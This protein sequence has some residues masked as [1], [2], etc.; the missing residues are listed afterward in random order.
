V[1]LRFADPNWFM[2]VGLAVPMAVLAFVWFRAMSGPRRW[3]AV[4]L[5]TLVLLIIAALLAGA[6]VVRTSEKMALMVVMD[7]S[8]SVREL[9]AGEGDT[10]AVDR[11]RAWLRAA[12]GQ[13]SR[14][15][16][17]GLVTFDGAAAPQVA[18]TAPPSRS[19]ANG[20]PRGVDMAPES[21]PSAGSASSGG[22]ESA[23]SRVLVGDVF[24]R[25]WETQSQ[26]VDGT[27]IASALRLAAGMLP[28]DAARRVLLISDGNQ[29]SGDA[30]SA[31]K[32]LFGR[33]A[34]GSADRTRLDVLAV[35]YRATNLVVVE[36]ID[37]PATAPARASITARVQMFASQATRGR[38]RVTTEGQVVDLDPNSVSN[39]K[40]V[41]IAAGSTTILVQVPLG[42]GR[43]HRLEATF[44]PD[45]S[46]DVSKAS[47]RTN[48][49]RAII[50][51]PGAGSVLLVDGVSR[52]QVDGP[53]SML[54]AAIRSADLA[55]DVT[56]PEGMP[57]ELLGLEK[58]DLVIL[59]NVPAD[60]VPGP[61]QQSLIRY[62]AELG[63]G[64]VMVGGPESFGA[65]GWRGQPLEAVLPVK[66]DLPERM[67]IPAVALIIVMDSSGSMGMRVSGSVRSQQD[68]ANEG[69][70]I[71]I[72]SLDKSDLIG[73]I[74]FDTR[75]D[76]VVPLGK[77]LK[78]DES[79]RLTRAIYPRG[80]TNMPPALE[81][82]Y[83]QLK[84]V[85]AKVKH[86]V[87]LSDGVSM[88]R[89][90]LVGIA[91]KM[92]ADG[93]KLSAIAV[94]DE[95]DNE[96]MSVMAT[97]G[98]GTYYRVDNPSTL[99][100]VFL[101]AVRVVRTPMV[102]EEPFVPVLPPSGSPL[103]AGLAELGDV[104]ALNG[105]TLTMPREQQAARA[106][107][108]AAD[109]AQA[110]G[111]KAGEAKAVG[112]V[113]LPSNNADSL[114]TL[115][116]GVTYAMVTPKGEPVLAHWQVG[117]GQVAAFTSDAHRWAAPW[118]SWPGYNAMWVQ[119]ARSVGR[120]ASG[121]PGE[122]TAEFAGDRLKVRFDAQDERARPLDMLTVTGALYTPTGERLEIRLPQVG[123]GR[124]EAQ[125]DP[126]LAVTAGGSSIETLAADGPYVITLTPVRPGDRERAPQRLPAVIGGAVKPQSSEY[127]FARSD[128][129]LLDEL[130]RLGGGEI[131]DWD[132]PNAARLF[133]R[134]AVAPQQTRLPLWPYLMPALLG[135]LLL[136]IATRRL[137]WDRLLSREF[138]ASLAKDAAAALSD[139]GGQVSGALTRLRGK[140]S[141]VGGD[142]AGAG[143]GT[144]TA[145]GDV[146]AQ[147]IRD[148]ARDERRAR[149][150][151]EF[152]GQPGPAFGGMQGGGGG[153]GGGTGGAA[154]GPAGGAA[155]QSSPEPAAPAESGLLAAKRRARERMDQ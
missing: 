107:G 23:A 94:G 143:G 31:A 51:T 127:R 80:G 102:R 1:T 103:V 45:A 77:N 62:V 139:R 44:E 48:T 25:P 106:E 149:R 118:L 100:R 14:E 70:A 99:P 136:D 58:Y 55:V 33:G 50:T 59:Q 69:A 35:R 18:P 91:Q 82:A 3:S 39:E 22:I 28:A 134:S 21:S 65:G 133:D 29:T 122:L 129:G 108:S 76:V 17:V 145:L 46:A 4:I 12:T 88:G 72:R 47:A 130:A 32:S 131:L 123:P 19:G 90:K 16:L 79:E 111:A 52:A 53:G 104:P 78:A 84:T 155:E 105:L 74:Q 11:A 42:A 119:I 27:D 128:D 113:D 49:A 13:R 98:G 30:L 20:Q 120:P 132:S 83:E 135:M 81:M 93:I 6:S 68:V 5:R 109:A 34:A 56:A 112:V 73:V 66:L 15:D 138:G 110:G 124:Y 137:A 151:A 38:L 63:G 43:V 121:R 148:R 153:T 60:L 67:V 144:M 116:G 64:L 61:A 2:L 89:G 147:Q 95:A 97:A 92:A 141:A 152:G 101:K 40:A 54:A 37:V 140:K 75:P 36:S 142:A 154:G 71:A 114:G 115:T 87:V 150:A 8:G 96:G 26:R 24:D 41:E 146:E 117:L 85:Q 7:T 9:A 126:R 10:S 57:Q 125:I 86:V